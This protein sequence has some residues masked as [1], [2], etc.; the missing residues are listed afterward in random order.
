MFMADDLGYEDASFFN[1]W[2]KT[3]EIDRMTWDELTFT[4][5]QANTLSIYTF[6]VAFTGICRV[7]LRSEFPETSQK[8]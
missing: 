1:G 3:P 4:D 8:L 5:F 7:L 2:V 6:A